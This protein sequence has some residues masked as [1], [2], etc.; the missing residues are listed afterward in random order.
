MIFDRLAIGTANWGKEYNGTKVPEDDQKQI[1]DYCQCSGIDM[2]DT[3]T[4][5]EWDWTKASSYFLKTVKIQRG[6]ILPTRDDHVRIM[7][8]TLE[9]YLAIGDKAGKRLFGSA[10]GVSIYSVRDAEKL[11]RFCLP[12]CIQVPYSIFDR[13]FENYF[14]SWKANDIKIH[15]RSVF[16]RGKLL[17]K[18]KP[19]ECIA[20]CLMNPYI[21]RV[22]L[23]A[24]SFEQFKQNLQ[25]LHR[26]NSAEIHDEN[27]LD[28]RKW[29]D[30]K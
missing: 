22:I 26:M 3:A 17:K 13:R 15:V 29:K 18:F 5:Y 23:G 8:H 10:A 2:I 4:A 20:F 19:W 9:A 7:G 16:L 1:L 14:G 24:D 11:M 6:E 12:A 30:N 25:P 27:I 28:P 21:D